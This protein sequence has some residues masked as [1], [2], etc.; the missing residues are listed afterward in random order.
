MH[1]E[2]KELQKE[3]KKLEKQNDKLAQELDSALKVNVKPFAFSLTTYGVFHCKS[4][5]LDSQ[6]RDKVNES[7]SRLSFMLCCLSICIGA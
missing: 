5:I 3:T 2:K 7:R 6:L 1:R 4:R